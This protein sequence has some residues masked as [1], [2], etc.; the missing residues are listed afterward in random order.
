MQITQVMN[1]A[2]MPYLH[3][4]VVFGYGGSSLVLDDL[5]F[6]LIIQINFSHHTKLTML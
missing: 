6:Y 2:N 3:E 4:V 5:K 1:L